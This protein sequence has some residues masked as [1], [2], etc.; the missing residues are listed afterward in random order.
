MFL[1]LVMTQTMCTLFSCLC[2]H[3]WTSNICS[4]FDPVTGS[5]H[6]VKF[7]RLNT[8]GDYNKNMDCD[9]ISD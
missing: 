4:V 3:L 5:M 7:L 1:V 2:C 8:T 9:D 6:E